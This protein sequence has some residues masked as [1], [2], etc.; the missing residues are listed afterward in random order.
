MLL[1]AFLFAFALCVGAGT[2][3]AEGGMSWAELNA[4]MHSGKFDI[5]RKEDV[6]VP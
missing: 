2:A 6:N 4:A 1:T 3:K 5:N